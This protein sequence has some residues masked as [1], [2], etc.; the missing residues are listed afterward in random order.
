MLLVFVCYGNMME[1]MEVVFE[2]RNNYD[3]CED[4]ARYLYIVNYFF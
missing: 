4:A 2:Q 1:S 3:L